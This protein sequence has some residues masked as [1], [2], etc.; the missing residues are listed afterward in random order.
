MSNKFWE[1]ELEKKSE[2]DIEKE[3]E[4][5][6][7]NAREIRNEPENTVESNQITIGGLGG[8]WVFTII[9]CAASLF[10][11]IIMVSDIAADLGTGDWEPVDGIVTN[12]YVSSSSDSEG[13]TTYCLH[14]SY[15]YVV[16]GISYDGDRVS[17]SSEHSCN[18]WSQNADDDY[19]EGEEITVY[20]DPSNPSESVLEPGLSGV[21]CFTCCFFIFPLVGLFL[22]YASIKSTIGRFSNVR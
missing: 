11:T 16:D 15:E 17:Y 5:I 20:Y 2:E 6:D 3:L 14:V 19:P 10:T 13:G 21:D 12:S 22:L 7:N 9:W 1:D 8:I 4:K 18:S